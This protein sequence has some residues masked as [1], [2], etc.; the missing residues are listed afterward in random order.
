MVKV[1]E[2]SL[3]V[4][5]SIVTEYEAGKG[6]RKLS[7]QFKI[8]ISTIQSIIKKWKEQGSVSNKPRTGAPKK[9]NPRACSK[10]V[11]IAKCNPRVTRKELVEEMSSIGVNVTKQTI[12]NVMKSKGL[13]RC[14]ARKV[15]LLKKKHLEARKKFATD[16]LKKEDAYFNKVLWS[17][18]TKIE[19][20]GNN[21]NTKVWRSPGTAYNRNNTLPT[22][23]HGGGNIM[24]W[25][26]FSSAGPGDLH[27]IKD[28]MNS[29]KYC[30]ILE[31]HL[32][33]SARR[34]RLGRRWVFQ[35]DNDPKHTSK[36]TTEWFKSHRINVLEWPS[37]SPDLNPIENLWKHLK[38]KVGER[39]PSNIKELEEICIEEWGKISPDV[40]KN[41]IS[42]Y[43]R[44]L[45]AVL[46]NKGHATKY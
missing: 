23:K 8:P 44:R 10:L 2:H 46:A 1:K 6:Y 7:E 3:Q 35:Q 5:N 4:R 22:V 26:C 31:N 19:L 37:Q 34:L 36:L 33:S 41:L 9:I 18:E 20:F 43:K 40:C 25:G 38:I 12:T 16:M 21:Y 28:T 45:E 30:E 27:I 14:Q 15:P 32:C 42:S 39:G 29:R 13:R 17:D 24:I 11:R